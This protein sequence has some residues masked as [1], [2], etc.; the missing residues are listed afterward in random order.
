MYRTTAQSRAIE[1]ALRIS[2]IPYQISAECASTS[3]R[4]S[5]TFLPPSAC[6]TIRP[7]PW[8]WNASSAIFRLG[9]DSVRARWKNPHLGGERTAYDARRLPGHRRS[10][11]RGDIPSSRKRARRGA[12]C[13]L[14]LHLA[15]IA[16]DTS[17]TGLF[18]AILDRTGYGATFD[19][20]EEEDLDRWANLLELRSELERLGDAPAWE[21]IAPYL[22]RVALV[23]DVDSLDADERGLS[24]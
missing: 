23:A 12:A 5:R 17:L 10:R 9:A 1:E 8:P 16:A 6:S 13:R 20:T 22:E 24:R 2:G 19:R 21:T 18:D 15:D 11:R 7:I 3:A 14:V 4:K